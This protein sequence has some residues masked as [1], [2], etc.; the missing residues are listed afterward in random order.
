M[1]HEGLSQKWLHLLLFID[2]LQSN[3]PLVPS[4]FI[5]T[6]QPSGFERGK[7]RAKALL[8]CHA[9]TSA[10]KD[11]VSHPQPGIRLMTRSPD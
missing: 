8:F 5:S 10:L 11:G 6:A 2:L 3:P 7:C 1:F 9:V 4:S